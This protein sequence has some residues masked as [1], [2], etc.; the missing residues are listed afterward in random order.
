VRA[1]GV[2][3]ALL[4][5][6]GC[7]AR[8]PVPATTAG[9]SAAVD[10][11]DFHGW[12]ALRIRNE[13]SEAVVV[14][15]IGRVMAFGLA[16][17]GATAFWNHP[18]IGPAL[19]PDE[20]GWINFG[21]DKAWPSPQDGWA[22]TSGKGWPPP[23]TFDQEPY[24]ATVAAGGIELV[25]AVDPA[26]GVRVRRRIEL[27]PGRP[28]MAIE[29]RYEK[30]AG[31]PVRVGVWTITQLA[32]PER[33][34]ARL[35]ERSAFPD[36]H[37]RRIDAP[38]SELRVEPRLLTLARDRAAKTMIGTDA[39][40]LAWIG[41]GPDLLIER[42]DGAGPGDWPGGAHAQIYT[43]SDDAEPYVELELFGPLREL[44]VGESAQMAVRYTLVPRASVDPITEAKRV[45]VLP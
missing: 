9:P 37:I 25:S 35:P 36:G 8:T 42:I 39:D 27:V 34:A 41:T 10:A 24:A 26:Y 22:A 21:G 43:S 33:V 32:G 6:L 29:T 7:A 45:F 38:P 31:A 30:V 2:V 12:P 20:N 5:L 13:A 17:S 40:A 1:T 16:G 18:R 19:V 4:T 28:V 3:S 23:R 14:P 44:R 15:A 11:V